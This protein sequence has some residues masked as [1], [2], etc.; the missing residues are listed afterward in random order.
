MSGE[1]RMVY[2]TI[3]D[4]VRLGIDYIKRRFQRTAINVAS[5]GLANSFLTSLIMTDLFYATFNE[6][7]GSTI[8]VDAYQYWLVAVALIVSV[9]GITNAMLISVYERY[10]EIGTMKCIGALDQHIL[11][12]FLIEAIIQGAAG[13]IIGYVLGVVA[14]VLS[15]GF[16]TGFNIIFMV[17]ITDLLSYLLST[18]LLS[19]LLSIIASMYPAWRASKLPPVEALSYEL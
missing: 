13:G 3:S 9:V 7:Q 5:I 12:L 2:F 19:I 8:G 4:A 11:M 16:T 14:A 6:Y 15:S 1:K 17:P 18:T 10:R